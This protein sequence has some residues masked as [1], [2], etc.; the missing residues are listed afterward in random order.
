MSWTFDA[1]GTP[2]K[3]AVALIEETA[4]LSGDSKEEF[5]RAIPALHSLLVMNVSKNFPQRVLHL[6]ANGH[7]SRSG[8]E[9]VDSTCNVSLSGLSAKL[10]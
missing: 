8:G 9:V 6:C 3:L 2:E 10:V 4:R 1:I 7:A 5:D